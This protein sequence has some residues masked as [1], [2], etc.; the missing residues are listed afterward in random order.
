M[1]GNPT[2][3]SVNG[4]EITS[5]S[6]LVEVLRDNDEDTLMFRFFDRS[7]ESLIFNADELIE[8]T[9]EVLED[10]SIRRQGSDRFMD[11]WEN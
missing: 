2:L 11:I 4:I 5:V 3:K 7:Q 8:S 10:N 1:F 9:E 6:H